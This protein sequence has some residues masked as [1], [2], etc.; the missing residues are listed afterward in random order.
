M[1]N[2]NWDEA[3]RRGLTG[4]SAET[5][6]CNCGQ[7]I[8]SPVEVTWICGRHGPRRSGPHQDETPTTSGCPECESYRRAIHQMMDAASEILW[9][10][11]MWNLPPVGVGAPPTTASPTTDDPSDA[12]QESTAPTTPPSSPLAQDTI[13][14]FLVEPRCKC[15]YP[16]PSLMSMGSAL[17]CRHCAALWAYVSIAVQAAPETG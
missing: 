15:A 8:G 13:P 3:M 6:T 14:K 2:R 1:S 5:P 10:E 11:G 7:A 17:R 12:A 9:P 16:Y 4:E